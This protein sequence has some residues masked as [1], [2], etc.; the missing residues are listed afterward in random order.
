MIEILLQA[1]PHNIRNL[2]RNSI[3]KPVTCLETKS[4][5]SQG[6]N[7]YLVKSNQHFCQKQLLEPN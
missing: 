5:S 7:V 4:Q 2:K 6:K 1:P 3:I